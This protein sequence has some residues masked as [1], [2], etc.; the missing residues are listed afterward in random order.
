MTVILPSNT[1]SAMCQTS[2]LYSLPPRVLL[3]AESVI[4]CNSSTSRYV[5]ARH[6]ILSCRGTP[7]LC[8]ECSNGRRATVSFTLLRV[9]V[10]DCFVLTHR[11]YV[12]PTSYAPSIQQ[13]T[14]NRSPDTP[15][16]NNTG[17]RRN[18]VHAWQWQWQWHG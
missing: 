18:G 2:D 14:S 1:Y 17:A 12:R 9:R 3:I 13:S 10:P 5:R 4:P 15:I 8:C 11:P 6:W 16:D 7:S